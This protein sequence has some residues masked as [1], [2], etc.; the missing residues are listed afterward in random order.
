[1]GIMGGKR[2]ASTYLVGV[3]DDQVLYLDPHEA[4]QVS[5]TSVIFF[6]ERFNLIYMIFII[7]LQ[8]VMRMSIGA[9]FTDILV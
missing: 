7:F 5:W 2:G 3:Q 1:M 9:R 4:Q 6:P 8:T